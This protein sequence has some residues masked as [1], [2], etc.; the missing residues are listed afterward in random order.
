MRSDERYKTSEERRKTFETP[1]AGGSTKMQD[2]VMSTDQT[3]AV[4]TAEMETRS[5][6]RRVLASAEDGNTSAGA[7][8]SGGSDSVAQTRTTRVGG[9]SS[10][11]ATLAVNDPQ[12]LGH[13]S[14]GPTLS[15]IWDPKTE[16]EYL[17]IIETETV[18]FDA[19]TV[20][21]AN[22]PV[23]DEETFEIDDVEALLQCE[24]KLAKKNQQTHCYKAVSYTHLTLPTKRIV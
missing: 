19:S 9:S 7:S 22:F 15:G 3:T 13:A 8:R 23:P 11:T 12:S 1:S 5:V 21:Y 4:T 14:K 10:S 18:K 17:K 24:I 20:Q 2:T 6:R 16:K